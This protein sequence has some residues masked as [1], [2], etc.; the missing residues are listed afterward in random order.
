MHNLYIF[1]LY[2]LIINTYPFWYM[3]LIYYLNVYI[4]YRKKNKYIKMN[5]IC[6]LELV[7]IEYKSELIYCGRLNMNN[8]NIE[9]NYN[10]YKVKIVGNRSYVICNFSFN[11]L[12]ETDKMYGSD[13]INIHKLPI[14]RYDVEECCLCLNNIGILVG[15]CGHQNVCGTCINLIDKCPVCNSNNIIKLN[16]LI[17]TEML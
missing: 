14:K 17:K 13:I 16:S 7:A 6:K 4:L 10:N 1:F 3:I 15:M 9:Y 5:Q 2:D 12:I 11:V 8:Y